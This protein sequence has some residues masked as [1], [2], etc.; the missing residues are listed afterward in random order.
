MSH[1]D[2]QH[3][4]W[5]E[6]LSVWPIEHV[7]KMTLE[8]YTKAGSKDSFTWWLE[9][10]TDH[11]GGIKGGSSFKFIVYNRN[12]ATIKES[13]NTSLYTHEYAW[14]KKFGTTPDEAFSEVKAMILNVIYAIQ[15][16]DLES[17]EQINMGPAY[18]WK[19]AFLYQNR[20]VPVVLN[21]FKK[22]PLL[23]A[24]HE[25]DKRLPQ[26]Q[27]YQKIMHN[28]DNQDILSFAIEVW[29]KWQFRKKNSN[30]SCW[31]LLE[32]EHIEE[33]IE[34]F[35]SEGIDSRHGTKYVLV[36]DG[37]IYPQKQIVGIACG[38]ANSTQKEKSHD[39]F[40][41]TQSK[42]ALESLGLQ[43]RLK[44]ERVDLIDE[45]KS[46]FIKW[47][48]A[49]VKTKSTVTDYVK[50]GLENGFR[51]KLIEL[52]IETGDFISLFQY[53][54]VD[55]L[56]SL[57]SRCLG[58]KDL[59]EWNRELYS[60]LPSA[61]IKHYIEFLQTFEV[62]K[63]INY[64]IVPSSSTDYD[65]IGAFKSLKTIDWGNAQNNKFE[66]GDI[67][68]IYSSSPVQALT[69]ETKVIKVN[70]TPD[71][72]L[73]NDRAYMHSDMRTLDNY[74]RLELIGFTDK[75]ALSITQLQKN[76]LKGNI[77]GKRKISGQL[78]EYILGVTNTM[79]VNENYP[80]NQIFYGPPGTGKTYYTI[81]KA[82]EIIDDSVPASRQEA[83]K[84]FGE[85]SD[86]GQISFVTF[87]QSYGYEEFVEGI[88]AETT[89][90]ENIKYEIKDGVFRRLARDAVK[91]FEASSSS[92]SLDITRI[93]NNFATFVEKKIAD[94]EQVVI[95]A[96]NR[97]FKVNTY[98]KEVKRDSSGNFK[99][100]V[101]DGGTKNQSLTL[102]VIERDL[103]NFLSGQIKTFHD[104][105]PTFESKSDYHGNAPY[106]FELYKTIK[107]FITNETAE[108]FEVSMESLK[109]YILIIDEINRGNIS[110]IFGELITLIEPSKRLGSDEALQV[111]LPYSG[112][113]FGVPSNLYI[114][115]T[116]NT[117][118]RSIALMDTALRRRFH[119]EE[120][121][122]DSSLVNDNCEGVNLKALLET[123]NNRIDYL[124]DRDH[125]I[126][127]AY[128][129]NITSKEQLDDVMSNKII[130]LL[131]EYFYDDWEKIQ[132][133]LGD[134]YKQFGRNNDT[135]AWDD[136]V[137]TYRFIQ[138]CSIQEKAIIGF[139]HEDIEDE[140]VTY[141]VN[142][143]FDHKSYQKIYDSSTLTQ[144]NNEA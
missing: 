136:T 7:E 98:L 12:D 143:T 29:D 49:R 114:I 16:N 43:V 112:K 34:Q 45:R 126:G 5:D 56:E 73:D 86:N 2:E 52:G 74:F 3:K 99:S 104:V 121:M 69:I 40:D 138:S 129:I 90:D 78:L 23:Y 36:F 91:N 83:K 113:E 89:E 85:L 139:D 13:N 53:D 96:E 55:F 21:I 105:K 93:I 28:R 42:K 88:K 127:H 100:F 79:K 22:E 94:S 142:S 72:L 80:L 82:L 124:Y 134:H 67:V 125:Q 24:L 54:N 47:A 35:D 27:L 46:N 20:E 58:G 133:V 130:P 108:T 144:E 116:M 14:L 44:S 59:S 102:S 120:M 63:K 38:I 140:Q 103:D 84:R 122:P 110:K 77:Q 32:Y 101:T 62:E 70:V 6:F 8:E 106:Y 26:Y 119:F 15:N 132:I 18:K 57:Y 95:T 115:G 30:Q 60:R 10:G 131:Q 48:E 141:R 92:N 81:N 65:A 109:K 37:Q 68:Y 51:E 61:A 123:I 39:D 4:K 19:I 11:L 50:H 31:E 1:I 117:A 137:N 41:A 64:W 76:G 107:L 71:Q 66:E 75:K 33:A 135:K 118:D 9:R 111:T 128:F 97:S 87:H 17:I 25:T